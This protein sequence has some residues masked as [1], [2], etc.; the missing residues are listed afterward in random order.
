MPE[1]PTSPTPELVIMPRPQISVMQIN[2]DEIEISVAGIRS[3]F[4]E[5]EINEVVIPI[6]SAAEVA[7]ALMRIV[8]SSS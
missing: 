4:K 7:A 3:D 6:E 1:N 8:N 2:G 5:V